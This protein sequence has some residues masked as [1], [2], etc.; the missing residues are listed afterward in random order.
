MLKEEKVPI[1]YIEARAKVGVKET[2]KKAIPYLQNFENVGLATNVQHIH[3]LDEVREL[4]LKEGKTVVMGDAGTVK[5]PGQVVGCDYSNVK[6]ASNVDGFLFV[7]G[8]MFHA[9]GVAL[10][11]GKPTII[12]DPFEKKSYPIEAEVKKIL[13]QRWANIC[14]ARESEAFGV[15]VGLKIGQKRLEEAI[16]IKKRLE[17]RGK[18]ATLLALN[19]IT[20]QALNNFPVLTAF[21]NT[22]C[23]RLSL[24]CPNFL[25]PVLTIKE[26]LVMLGEMGWGELIR[27][28]WI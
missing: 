14:E 16:R 4:L 2:I 3:V 28:G 22:A 20:P 21:V 11:T 10:A 18:K 8:G 27:K 6:S 17:K 12:A 25:K 9:I 26:T 13:R 24:D 7:G 5:N 15:L 1:V 23:P 19:E